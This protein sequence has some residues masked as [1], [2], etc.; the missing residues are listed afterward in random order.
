MIS[1]F[2]ESHAL[3]EGLSRALVIVYVSQMYQSELWLVKYIILQSF[4]YMI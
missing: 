3:N 2:D 4:E 1:L